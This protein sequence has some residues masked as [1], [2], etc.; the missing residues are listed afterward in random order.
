M[1]SYEPTIG[2]AERAL[3]LTNRLHQNGVLILAGTDTP[4]PWTIT[5]ESLHDELELFVRAGLSPADALQT[6]TLN[7][8]KYLGQSDDH[9][10]VFQDLG[11]SA[12]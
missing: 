4:N 8:A 9:G 11:I 2:A 3:Q 10:L 12:F 1:S 5:G 7:A 6:A